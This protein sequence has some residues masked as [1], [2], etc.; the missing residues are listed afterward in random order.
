M[1][2]I[3]SIIALFATFV[4]G[5]QT[6]F[7]RTVMTALTAIGTAKTYDTTTNV[8]TSYLVTSAISGYGDITYYFTNTTLTGSTSGTVIVQGSQT[9]TFATVGDWVTLVTDKTQSAM[10]DQ[11]VVSGTTSGYY[12]FPKHQFKYIRIRYISA[13]TQTSRMT[14]TMYFIRPE[15]WDVN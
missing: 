10:T 5:A 14:G 9:G 3:L 4:C 8:D 6:G 12:S 11:Y 15:T 2:K 1:K 13:G 7:Q